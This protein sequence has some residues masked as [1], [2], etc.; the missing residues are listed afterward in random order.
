MMRGDVYDDMKGI[1]GSFEALPRVVDPAC[2]L[3]AAEI[4]RCLLWH[5]KHS[6]ASRLAFITQLCKLKN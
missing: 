6:F 4:A 5:T 3:I 1:T 2:R